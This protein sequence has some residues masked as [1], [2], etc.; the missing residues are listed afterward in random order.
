[1]YNLPAQ[2]P[3]TMNFL[4]LKKSSIFCRGWPDMFLARM[5]TAICPAILWGILNT[6]RIIFVYCFG[7]YVVD[8]RSCVLIAYFEFRVENTYLQSQRR[9]ESSLNRTNYVRNNIWTMTSEI[10]LLL[11]AFPGNHIAKPM[12]QPSRRVPLVSNNVLFFFK[13][14]L[15]MKTNCSY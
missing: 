6:D 4:S 12:C 8:F 7:F 13:Y 2:D 3:V 9:R 5:S 14:L 15:T 10:Q 11:I 1:M